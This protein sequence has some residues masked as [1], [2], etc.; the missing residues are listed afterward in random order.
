M[1]LYH[2]ISIYQ[3]LACIC[4]QVNHHKGEQSVCILPDFIVDKY[5]DCK[6]LETCRIFDKV[7]LF[8]YQRMPVTDSMEMV[9]QAGDSLCSQILPWDV[10]DFEKIYCGGTHFPFASYLVTKQVHFN[11][12]EDASGIFLNIDEFRQAHFKKHTT[13]YKLTEKNGLYDG[14]CPY[15]KHIYADV[16]PSMTEENPKLIP[17]NV[18]AELGRMSEEQLRDIRGAF[19]VREIDSLTYSSSTVFITDPADVLKPLE[20]QILR[21]A[22]TIDYYNHQENIIVKPHPDDWI[23]HSAVLQNAVTLPRCFPME[24]MGH[25]MEDEG[26][27]VIAYN[28]AVLQNL[29]ARDLQ[30]FDWPYQLGEFVKVHRYY[31]AYGLYK[32]IHQQIS[33]TFGLLGGN[34]SILENWARFDGVKITEDLEAEKPL[35][36]F[37]GSVDFSQEDVASVL[38]RPGGVV[39]MDRLYAPVLDIIQHSHIFYIPKVLEITGDDETVAERESIHVFT[40]DEKMQEIAEGFAYSRALPNSRMRVK[41]AAL[42]DTSS[43]EKVELRE[44]L[45]AKERQLLEALQEQ[46]ELRSML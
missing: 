22:L 30:T 32:E 20:K 35:F 27:H 43:R 8:S 33:C 10:A 44:I 1:I 40:R 19:G 3:L 14:S 15:V 28:T 4:L 37:V 21:N 34:R 12:L 45:Q 2:A 42:A 18:M 5:P 9:E 11:Y 38:N 17:F 6:L 31:A 29:K 13:M 25:F 24:L 39:V 41:V 7:L 23:C 36:L 26:A 46:E 16:P